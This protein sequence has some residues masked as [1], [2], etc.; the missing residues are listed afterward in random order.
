MIDSIENPFIDYNSDK[1]NKIVIPS[2]PQNVAISVRISDEA[3]IGIKK[4]LNEYVV[5][6][7][8]HKQLSTLLEQLGLYALYIERPENLTHET[9]NV[10]T[11]DLRQLGYEDGFNGSS[12]EF[13]VLFNEPL[14]SKY[15]CAYLRGY[16]EGNYIRQKAYGTSGK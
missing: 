6:G 11:E 14:P 12:K 7:L 5:K 13:I 9:T 10:T 16:Y 4:Y 15:Q 1:N 3:L 2:Y 8:L